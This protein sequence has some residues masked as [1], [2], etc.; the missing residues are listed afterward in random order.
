MRIYP[1]PELPDVSVEWIDQDCRKGDEMVTVTLDGI[2][3]MTH[4][5]VA[6]PCTELKAVFKDVKRERYRIAAQLR[7]AAGAVISDQMYDVD[8]RDGLDETTLL[9]FGAF[10]DFRVAW[11][12]E[13]GATCASLGAREVRVSM[14]DQF[15]LNYPCEIGRANGNA[16]DGDFTVTLTAYNSAGTV[17]ESAPQDVTIDSTQLTNLGTFTLSPLP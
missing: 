17:A 3:S 10:D 5:E 1:D 12:F 9:Y 15:A 6:V 4:A 14:S 11:T 13:N 2:D 8:L 7:E 16:P